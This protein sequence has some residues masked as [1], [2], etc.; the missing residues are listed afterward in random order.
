MT[1][2]N[3]T[4]CLVMEEGDEP[5]KEWMVSRLSESLSINS[6]NASVHSVLIPEAGYLLRIRNQIV[7]ELIN[8]GTV[9]AMVFYADPDEENIA[10]ACN[11]YSNRLPEAIIIYCSKDGKHKDLLG[12]KENIDFQIGLKI[13]DFCEYIRICLLNKLIDQATNNRSRR[14][15]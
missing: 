11:E 5:G 15:N 10:Y 7:D 2:G 3:F 6:K 14:D 9:D 1:S 4:I 8:V 12:A 13:N